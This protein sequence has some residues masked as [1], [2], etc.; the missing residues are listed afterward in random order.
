MK[1]V[2]FD[3]SSS[4]GILKIPVGRIKFRKTCRRSRNGL[5]YVRNRREGVKWAND[6]LV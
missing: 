4:S 2:N 1:V 3:A 6:V 5:E